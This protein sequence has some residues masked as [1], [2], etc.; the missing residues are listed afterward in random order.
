MTDAL[1]ACLACGVRDADVHM[2]LV[3]LEDEGVTVGEQR[4]VEVPIVVAEDRHQVR[5]MEYREVRERYVNEPRCRDRAAC[6]RRQD[7]WRATQAMQV[8]TPPAADATRLITPERRPSW[9]PD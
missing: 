7:A 1:H 3:D 6:R 9:I 5:G 4:L 2:A 8:A